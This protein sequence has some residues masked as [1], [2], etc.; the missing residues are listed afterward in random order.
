MTHIG[1]LVTVS[2]YNGPRV[3]RAMCELN[4]VSDTA[5]LVRDGK[6]DRWGD[7]RELERIAGRDLEV[8][9][10]G[11]CVVLPGFVD[12]HTHFV[13]G[14]GREEEFERRA[15]GESYQSI[16]A[17]GGGI[18]STVR[19]TRAASEDELFKSAKRRLKWAIRNGT[20]TLEIKSGYGLS[21]EDELK[22][23]R[24]IRRLRNPLKVRATFLGAHEVP[25]E[26]QGCKEQYI[27]LLIDEVLPVVAKE[28]LAQYADIFCERHLFDATDTERYMKA[29]FAFGL[30]G[31]MHVDQLSNSGGALL[32]AT[33]GST[34]ADHLEQ[35]ESSG[36]A[37]LKKAN[38][39]PV[40]L[41]GSVYALGLKKYPAARE[42]IETG[43]PLVL[44]TDFNPGSSP[45]PSI[46]M[47]ISLAVTQMRMSVAEA[48]VATTINA[49]ASLDMADLVG[50]I[51][52]G[53][54]ADF[55]IHDCTDYRELG[56]FFGRDSAVNV[57]M[58]GKRFLKAESLEEPWGDCFQEFGADLGERVQP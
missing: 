49:A 18:R 20:T 44:A 31:R 29:A 56:Y 4:V 42:M 37:A 25:D 7:A 35:T 21:F 43:L 58:S 8:V 3:G 19:H 28:R 38:V 22:M 24:V 26:F 17:S 39:Y 1:Q 54:S 9:D 48:I 13:F 27:D 36:I 6:F 16:A 53:K 30:K 23:L 55:V 14:G 45:V 15:L 2:G 5:L 40:L 10:A 47:V 34:T 46:P 12:A 41:P 11:G 32:A 52:P 33:L 57:F 50:S 51:A